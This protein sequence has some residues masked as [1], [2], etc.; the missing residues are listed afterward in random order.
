VISRV[1]DTSALYGHFVPAALA[2]HRNFYIGQLGLLPVTPG[3]ASILKATSGGQSKVDTS[4]LTTIVGMTFDDRVRLYVLEAATVA[5]FYEA[6]TGAVVR[7]NP[8]GSL[9]TIS[10]GLSFPSG[11][12]FGP[13]GSLYVSNF[14]FRPVSGT[15]AE[16]RP[17]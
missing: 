14:G 11:I 10:T 17:R 8:N 4:G 6:G 1:I 13:D 5:G 2:Y 16:Q 3:T 12:T 7:V 15:T 9:E